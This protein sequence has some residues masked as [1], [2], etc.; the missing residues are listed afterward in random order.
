[1]RAFRNIA[2]TQSIVYRGTLSTITPRVKFDDSPR[3]YDSI[4]QSTND[5]PGVPRRVKGL[6][7]VEGAPKILAGCSIDN[8]TEEAFCLS[9]GSNIQWITKR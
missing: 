8:F 9:T 3:S 6:A 5:D 4:S 1:M 2:A 7:Q